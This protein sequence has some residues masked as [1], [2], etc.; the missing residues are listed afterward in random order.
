ME[1]IKK[2][3]QFFVM[4]PSLFDVFPRSSR[5]GAIFMKFGTGSDIGHIIN[6][7][8]FFDWSG[9]FESTG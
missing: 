9:S 2:T 3:N 5:A 6:Q 1:A 7:F 4:K 8:N